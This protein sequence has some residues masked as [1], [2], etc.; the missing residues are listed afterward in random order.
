MRRRA[1]RS[2]FGFALT[3]SLLFACTVWL[4]A[5]PEAAAQ[6]KDSAKGASTTAPAGTQGTILGALPADTVLCVRSPS[7]KSLGQKLKSTPFWALR[8][9]PDVKKVLDKVRTDAAAGLAQAQK[10]LGFDPVETLAGVEGEV[11]IA[12][13]GLEALATA[14]GESL[15]VGQM[16]Q[17][18]N[19]ENVP[20]LIAADAGGYAPQLHERLEKLMA[21]AVKQGAKKETV[22][23]KGGKITRLTESHEKAKDGDG[24]EAKGK[25]GDDEGDSKKKSSSDKPEK[26]EKPGNEKKGGSDFVARGAADPSALAADDDDDKDGKD[27][28]DDADEKDDKDEKKD[29]D[30]EEAAQPPVNVYF[31]E[32]GSRVYVSTSRAMLE[33]CMQK[34]DEPP[35]QGLVSTPNFSETYRQ[36]GTGDLYFFVNVK[37][38]TTSVGSALSTTFF[39]FFWQK[40]EA[41]VFGKSLNTLGIALNLEPSEIH[42]TVFV[43]NSGTSDGVLGIFKNEPFS[44]TDAAPVPTDCQ[45]FSSLSFNP[46]QLGKIIKD[47]VQTA[48]AFQGQA[49]DVDSLTQEM[50]GVKLSEVISALGNKLHSFAGVPSTDGNPLAGAN[51]VIDLKN[52]SA[53]QKVLKKLSELSQG[54]FTPEKFKDRDIYSYD[55][56]SFSLHASAGEKHLV[57]SGSRS[58]V[59]KVIRKSQEDAGGAPPGGEEFKKAAAAMPPKV[60]MV[61]YSAP[62]YFKNFIKSLAKSAGDSPDEEVQTLSKAA[63]AL[64]EAVGSSVAFGVWRDSGFFADTHLKLAAPKAQ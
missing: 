42:E 17:N 47:A 6:E 53:L 46:E 28:K 24:A 19:T 4:G 7:L 56:G 14:L 10:E 15:S 30:V 44:P 45:T 37:Q 61:G 39:A 49:K 62:D 26:P 40:I 38:F 58:E 32:L 50:I 60:A 52:G 8:D 20:L 34:P 18:F 25:K 27:D 13:G 12:L 51:Y 48:M 9:H 64:A 5:P 59:E 21:F 63:M 43:H 55:Q 33:K 57:L 16:P 22:D 36:T 3:A 11:V 2:L 1:P 54:Q 41:L 29:D 23:F 31:G 35:A